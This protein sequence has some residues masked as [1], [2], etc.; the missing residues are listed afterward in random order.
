M[1]PVINRILQICAGAGRRRYGMEAAS[2]TWHALQ[3]AS[4]A[5]REGAG[6]FSGQARPGPAGKTPGITTKPGM[7]FTRSVHRRMAG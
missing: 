2:R 3:C 6:R 5:E 7:R 4:L 1:S